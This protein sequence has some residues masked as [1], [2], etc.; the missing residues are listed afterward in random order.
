MLRKWR[1]RIFFAAFAKG[2]A[3]PLGGLD[4]EIIFDG[5]MCYTWI[6][7]PINRLEG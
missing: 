2:A 1:V 6:S 3:R 5:K 4:R 7:V